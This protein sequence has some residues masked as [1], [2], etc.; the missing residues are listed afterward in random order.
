MPNL[1]HGIISLVGA[2]FTPALN[3]ADSQNKQ[4]QDI[5]TTNTSNGTDIR[6]TARVAPTV[7]DIIGAYKSRLVNGCL[8]I[9]KSKNETMGKLLQRNYYEHIIRNEKSYQTISEYILNNPAKWT[10]D[11]FYM[12]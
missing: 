8:D 11:K 7:S 3:Y 6:T 4:N 2:G 1:I 10:E 12:P 9:Y 5:T